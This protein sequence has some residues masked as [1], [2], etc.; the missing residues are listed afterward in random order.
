MPD[1]TET[2]N[3]QSIKY[4]KESISE[5]KT[6]MADGFAQVHAKI[7][8]LNEHYVRRDEL[9]RT[10]ARVKETY[11]ST[12]EDKVSALQ[13]NQTWLVRTV[14]AIIIAAVLGIILTH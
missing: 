13:S 11:I 3:S 1:V 2:L 6:S 10:I 14:G 7:D 8:I 4:L 9:D 5:L 12:L